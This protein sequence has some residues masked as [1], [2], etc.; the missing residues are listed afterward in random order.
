A[1]LRILGRF[2]KRRLGSEAPLPLRDLPQ[3]GL[4]NIIDELFVLV[5]ISCDGIRAVEDQDDVAS[6][7]VVGKAL[8]KQFL[9]AA[10]RSIRGKESKFLVL[11][12]LV[13]GRRGQL[14]CDE[15]GDPR[16]KHD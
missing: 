11:S 4:E 12:Y 10:A 1:Q 14:G 2:R 3:A 9:A 15:E 7:L 5:D 16:P 6:G 13:P 8:L